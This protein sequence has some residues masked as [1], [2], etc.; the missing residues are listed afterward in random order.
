MKKI[1]AV[2]AIAILLFGCTD[3][4][5][6]KDPEVVGYGNMVS[7]NYILTV[8]GKFYDTNI[9]SVARANGV[10]ISSDSTKYQPLTF[11]A[12]LGEGL[13]DGFVNEVVGMESGETKNFTISSQYGY[14]LSDP[15]LVYEM[16]RYYEKDMI[17]T[18]PLS[19]FE[20]RNIDIEEGSS[21]QTD[22]GPVFISELN[23]SHANLTYVFEPGDVFYY[24]GLPQR[25]LSGANFKYHIIIDVVEGE[26]YTTLSPGT[27]K[28]TT[29]YV[30]SITN[31]TIVFDENHPLAGKNLDYTVTVL[32]ISKQ[33]S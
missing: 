3:P 13:I 12:L 25:V 5:V 18:V 30:T 14:G 29:L 19:Y 21:F 7:V 8:D 26:A 32:S 11:F 1:F 9:E 31:D 6:P 15:S 10:E 4:D 23:E 22:I 16:E 33:G 27:G 20:D 2:L 17:D 28:L 24:G